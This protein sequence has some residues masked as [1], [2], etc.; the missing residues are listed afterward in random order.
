MII[1]KLITMWRHKHHKERFVCI[2]HDGTPCVMEPHEAEEM[3]REAELAHEYEVS[4]VW[5]T[6]DQFEKL[7]EFEGW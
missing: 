7:A 2:S 4:D 3:L 5:L 1:R 6:R